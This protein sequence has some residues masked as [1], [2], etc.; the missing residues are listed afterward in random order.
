MGARPFELH[1]IE[2]VDGQVRQAIKN[3]DMASHWRDGWTVSYCWITTRQEVVAGVA[4]GLPRS[5]L[6]VVMA[7]P[8]PEDE[9]AGPVGSPVRPG[10]SQV[11][12]VV[13]PVVVAVAVGAV[14]VWAPWGAW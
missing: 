5:Y 6:M 10:L 13:W 7:P 9:V 14:L 12:L 1:E 8:R 2:L 3:E 11:A 4:K